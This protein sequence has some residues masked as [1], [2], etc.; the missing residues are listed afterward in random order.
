MKKLWKQC[1]AAIRGYMH[2]KNCWG[3]DALNSLQND[4]ELDMLE[5]AIDIYSNRENIGNNRNV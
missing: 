4:K 2:Q 3:T 5:R 1:W